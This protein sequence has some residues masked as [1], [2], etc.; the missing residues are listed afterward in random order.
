MTDD[1][2]DKED[3]EEQLE[4]DEISPEEAGFMEGYDN[5]K[6]ITC[7]KCS[8]VLKNKKGLDLEKCHEQVINGK[9]TW[10]C[11]DCCEE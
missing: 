9:V 11:D 7:N 8:K 1:I 10:F 4:N 2:Y 6:L 5:T 3:V